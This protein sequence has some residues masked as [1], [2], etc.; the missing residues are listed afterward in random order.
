MGLHGM[1]AAF[2]H[3]A[4]QV[5]DTPGACELLDHGDERGEL[6]DGAVRDRLVDARQLLHHDATGAD[7]HMPNFGIA[8]LA[9]RK[10]DAL[11]PAVQ[12]T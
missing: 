3:E 9:L 11:A 4:H 10:A 12:N 1:H 8:E 6:G 2:G 7:I 5:T